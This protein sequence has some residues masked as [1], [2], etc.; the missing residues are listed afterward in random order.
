MRKKPKFDHSCAIILVVIFSIGTL[1]CGEG[2]SASA[3]SSGWFHT[4]ALTNAGAVKCWGNNKMGQLGDNTKRDSK[5]PVEVFGLSSGVKAISAGRFHTCAI[6]AGGRVQCWGDNG[7][8]QL[9]DGTRMYK[10]NKPVNVSGLSSGVSAISAGG[11]H[12]CALTNEGAVLCWGWNEAGQLGDGTQTPNSIIPV[13]VFRLSGAKSIACGFAHTCA[14]TQAGGVKC[15][16]WNVA[17][18]LGDG[19]YVNKNIPTDVLGLSSGVKAVSLGFSHTC[20]LSNE[21]RVKCWGYNEFGQL[22]DGSWE[23]KTTPIEVLG[24]SSEVIAISAG[25]THSCALTFQGGVKCWGGNQFGQLGDKSKT[26]K[27]V[28]TD[29]YKLSSEVRAISAGWLH[30]CAI[31]HS[32]KVFCWG[33]NDFGQL[34]MSFSHKVPAEVRGF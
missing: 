17:G 6:T 27:N 29:V 20:A 33:R 22:G 8:G 23:T 10:A 30:T 2:E 16:G 26:N 3:I 19:T 21:G 12:T 31:N 24:I 34:G 11:H 13:K 32:E 14:L 5:T 7:Y 4:C 18:Q 9:G 25:F 15:W 1:G 28:P